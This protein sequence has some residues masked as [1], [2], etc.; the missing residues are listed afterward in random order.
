MF[1]PE[2]KTLI[3]TVP[4][5]GLVAPDAG[6]GRAFYLN[7]SG[8]NYNLT[9]LDFTNLQMVSSIAISNII[10]TPSSLIRWG[11]DGLA[12]RTTG[13]Q[14]FVIRTTLADDR[15]SDGLGDAWEFAHFGGLNA[16]NGGPNDDPDNDGFTN[17]QEYRLGLDPLT[18]DSPRIMGF[19]RFGNGSFHL[20]VLGLLG[21][22]YALMASTNLADWIPLQSFVGSDLPVALVDSEAGSFASRFYRFVPLATVFRPQ[23][24]VD[25]NG[26][27]G[28]GFD[29]KVA[30][31]PGVTY[32]IESST[33]LIN[34]QVV[35]NFISTN[36][37]MHLRD[38][39]A[40]GVTRQFYR[41]A[42]Q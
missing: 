8:A 10:G 28:S 13:G 14:I 41:A 40:P 20:S 33:N 9:C 39:T 24:T 21:Q 2:T 7:G 25:A 6:D 38:T 15:D 30:G 19:E 37:S 27:N 36:S 32:R 18:Y 11:N 17:L 42:T 3:G 5:G 12:F 35:T 26:L 1:D 31:V 34:W 23:I 4:Y 16:Q 22:S 29:L